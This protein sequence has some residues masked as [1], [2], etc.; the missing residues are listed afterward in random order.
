MV[1]KLELNEVG[2]GAVRRFDGG[3]Y[4]IVELPV[5]LGEGETGHFSTKAV[6]Y[7]GANVEGSF[8]STGC[9]V[10]GQWLRVGEVVVIGNLKITGA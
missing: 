2:K 1:A 3:Q 6:P 8:P 9:V 7:S 5:E 10:N 4:L